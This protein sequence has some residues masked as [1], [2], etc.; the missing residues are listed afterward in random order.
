[1]NNTNTK[2]QGNFNL[3]LKNLKK[4]NFKKS[5]VFLNYITVNIHMCIVT[6]HI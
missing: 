2:I 5:E 1:M 6:K 4:N 3:G